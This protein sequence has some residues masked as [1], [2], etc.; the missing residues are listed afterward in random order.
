MYRPEMMVRI[1]MGPTDVAGCIWWKIAIDGSVRGGMT[2]SRG[3]FTTNPDRI[4]G[5]IREVTN[6]VESYITE[7]VATSSGVQLDLLSP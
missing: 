2:Q 5:N 3:V 1:E 6:F 4:R 7:M